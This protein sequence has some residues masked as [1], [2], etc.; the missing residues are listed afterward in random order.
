MTK[1]NPNN[2]NETKSELFSWNIFKSDVV[3]F[4]VKKLLKYFNDF[5]NLNFS[6]LRLN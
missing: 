1:A 6:V 2:G 4:F 5:Q 3:Y